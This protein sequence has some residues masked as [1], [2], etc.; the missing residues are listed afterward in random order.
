MI[1]ELIN[2]AKKIEKDVQNISSWKIKASEGLHIFLKM[3]RDIK[4]NSR[5]NKA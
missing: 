1:R 3:E 5:I 2:F 4:Y